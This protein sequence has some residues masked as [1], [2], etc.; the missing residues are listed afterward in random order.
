[1]NLPPPDEMTRIAQQQIVERYVDIAA[2]DDRREWPWGWFFITLFGVL[3]AGL[4]FWPGASL[5]RKMYAIVHGVCAQ[6]H[7]IFLGDLQFP[8]CARDSGIYLSFMLTMIYIYA[9][10]RERAG[11]L[12]WPIG[13]ALT[14]FVVIMGI[15]G[16]NSVFADLGRPHLYPPDNF[17]RVLTGMGMGISIAVFLHLMLVS[18]LRRD[19]DY[20]QPV[21]KN[22]WELGGIIALDLLA[23]AAIYGNLSFM[24]WPLAF[25]SFFG[26]IGVLFL[27]SLLLIS[28]AM[29]YESSVTSLRQLARPAVIAMAPPLLILGGMSWFRFWLEGLGLGI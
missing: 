17:L 7:N 10:G 13:V 11:G 29:G 26:I 23:L 9:I 4:L 25:L 15:D 19:V 20:S 18:T 24:F 27:V 22:G 1:M 21:L 6:K 5:E 16:F 8:L 28:L 2:P 14:L 12:R 3:L